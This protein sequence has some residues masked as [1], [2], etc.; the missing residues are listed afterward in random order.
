MLKAKSIEDLSRVQA[1]MVK[2]LATWDVED[3]N[4]KAKSI[5]TYW[6]SKE[7]SSNDGQPVVTNALREK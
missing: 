3:P 6:N 7:Q 4:P 5:E 1:T 2:P